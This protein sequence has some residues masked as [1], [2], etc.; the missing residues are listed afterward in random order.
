MEAVEEFDGSVVIVSHSE[1]LLR[2]IPNKF[3]ICREG[4]QQLF[5]GDY[6]SFIEKIGWEDTAEVKKE[7]TSGKETKEYALKKFKRDHDF[8]PPSK[9]S[10]AKLEAEI[11]KRETDESQWHQELDAAIKEQNNGLVAAIARKM[12]KTKKGRMSSITNWKRFTLNPMKYL[13]NQ[14]LMLLCFLEG[15]NGMEEKRKA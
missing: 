2:R 1:E 10:I 6:D 12:G 13:I 4:S 3:L 7:E 15:L 9:G 11:Q 14:L 8:S 5:L